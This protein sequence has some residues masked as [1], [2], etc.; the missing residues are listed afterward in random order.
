MTTIKLFDGD[1]G[2]E[3]MCVRCNLSRADS[4]IEVDY[5]TGDGWKGTQ[6]QC[7]DAQHR[8]AGLAE[9]GKTLAAQAVEMPVDDFECETEE[10]VD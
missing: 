10:L 4:G 6:Y 5:G 9:I 3:E 7:A 8:T 2:S 1:L